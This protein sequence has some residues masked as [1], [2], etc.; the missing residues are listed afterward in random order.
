MFQ[1]VL[2]F[3]WAQI[4]NI[5]S[6]F[7]FV[8]DLKQPIAYQVSFRGPYTWKQILRLILW[9]IICIS[10]V[11]GNALVVKFFIRKYD[12]PGSRFVVGL[13]VFDLIFSVLVLFNNII[14]DTY[15][16][17]HWPFGTVGCIMIKHL[18][19][20]NYYASGWMLVVI[21]FERAR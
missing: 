20:S 10:G 1:I 17:V 2:T 16:Y 11:I 13:A 14:I 8:L 9:G 3:L 15:D 5:T 18:S 6:L 21:S 4:E 7:V 12:Q 19:M